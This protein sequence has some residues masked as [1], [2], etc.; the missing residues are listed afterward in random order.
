[1][2]DEGD[3]PALCN[4]RRLLKVRGQSVLCCSQVLKFYFLETPRVVPQ[5]SSNDSLRH[6]FNH[7]FQPSSRVSYVS[8]V[9]G[10]VNECLLNKRAPT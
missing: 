10:E 9:K 8:M 7:Y 3:R 5:P 2:D 4:H 1:M 6:C